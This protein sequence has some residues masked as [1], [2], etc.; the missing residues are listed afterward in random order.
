[1]KD[2]KA[3]R[4]MEHLDEDLILSAMDESDLTG[5]KK[6]MITGGNSMKKMGWKAWSAIAAAVVL[7]LSAVLITSNLLA[8]DVSTIIALDVNPSIEIEIDKNEKIRDVEALNADAKKVLAGMELEGVDLEVAVNAIIGSMVKN[9]YLS[10]EQNSILV[11]IDAKDG[12]SSDALKSKLAG[13]INTLLAGSNISASVITQ[14]FDKDGKDGGKADQNNISA[15]KSAWISKILN[16]GLLD[17]NGVPYTYETLA[18]LKVNELKLILE[19]KGLK[20]DGVNVSGT[21]S[22]ER[23]ISAE[24]AQ[25][26]ALQKAGVATADITHLE[27][28]MDYDDDHN[29]M[30]YEIEFLYNGQ[31][32]EYEILA[33]SGVI[34]EEEIKPAGE[35]DYN[36][37]KITLPKD[38]LSREAALAAAYADAGLDP[39]TVRRPEIEIDRERELYVY[40]IEFKAN[41]VEYEYLINAVTGEILEK[42]QEPID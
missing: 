7:I 16:A 15:A 24:Q 26:A 21:A 29:A 18:K 4:A 5:N 34:V 14:S 3:S 36:D 37:Q 12:K 41:G 11:S 6:R 33:E 39:A 27:R 17:A 35:D 30:V 25:E 8:E 19:S 32:Y 1:M 23:Y 38:A 10:T 22:G 13:K 2:R 28:E 42:E 40:E 20:V 9:G 31:K